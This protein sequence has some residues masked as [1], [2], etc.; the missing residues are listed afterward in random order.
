MSLRL[1]PALG[2]EGL[3]Y[4]ILAAKTITEIPWTKKRRVDGPTGAVKL[5]VPSTE[6]L[7]LFKPREEE[8]EAKKKEAERE[9]E[10]KKQIQEKSRK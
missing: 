9:A 6:D 8:K 1:P 3:F 7:A 2:S 10:K 4:K 5:D